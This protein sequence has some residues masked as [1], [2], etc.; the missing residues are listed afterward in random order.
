MLL[1]WFLSKCF[2]SSLIKFPLCFVCF[3]CAYSY[4]NLF[5]CMPKVILGVKLQWRFSLFV[6]TFHRKTAFAIDNTRKK[7]LWLLLV[8]EHE[9]GQNQKFHSIFCVVRCYCCNNCFKWMAYS[10]VAGKEWIFFQFFNSNQIISEWNNKFIRC[11]NIFNVYSTVYPRFDNTYYVSYEF[12]CNFSLSLF[13][14]QFHWIRN[15]S[16]NGCFPLIV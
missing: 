7:A 11:T 10:E 6:A 12:R 15:E 13:K 4:V 14:F 9:S 8:N 16:W 3:E 2:S 5:V 1:T